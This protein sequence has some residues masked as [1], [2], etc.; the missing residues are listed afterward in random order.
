MDFRLPALILSEQPWMKVLKSAIAQLSLG[1]LPEY[2]SSEDMT[3]KSPPTSHGRY[4][5]DWQILV[6]EPHSA[7]RSH[8]VHLA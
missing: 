2:S 8:R 7:C 6:K 1:E 5:I 3:L 4:S